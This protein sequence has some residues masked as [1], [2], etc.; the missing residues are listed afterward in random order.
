[1]TENIYWILKA[2]I[3]DRNLDNLKRLAEE[4][5][6]ITKTE[7][8][9]MAY[10]WSIAQDRGTLHIY[11]RYVNTEAA[12]AHMAN[13]SAQLPRLMELVTVTEIECYG[14]AGSDFRE[15]A[16]DFPMTYMETFCGFRKQ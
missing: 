7:P 11:E 10:E 2:K 4:C 15:A 16:K 3:G 13:L 12:M 9:V 6:E 14:K 1:M 8:G 5:C